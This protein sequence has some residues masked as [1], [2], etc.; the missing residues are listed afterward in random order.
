MLLY[1]CEIDLVITQSRIS[2]VS[3]LCKCFQVS[4]MKLT[5]QRRWVGKIRDLLWIGTSDRAS[6]VY[7]IQN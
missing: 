4:T 3:G 6:V 7:K 2:V 1:N 5:C